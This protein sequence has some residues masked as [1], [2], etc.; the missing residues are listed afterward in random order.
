VAALG[1]AVAVAAHGLAAIQTGIA[2]FGA[3]LPKIPDVVEIE[4]NKLN[5][6][7]VKLALELKSIVAPA[8]VNQLTSL[9]DDIDNVIKAFN[10]QVDR[11]PKALEDEFTK[12]RSDIVKAAEKRCNSATEYNQA[13]WV[14][15][16]WQQK[17]S[18]HSEVI[19]II[20]MDKNACLKNLPPIKIKL[21]TRVDE[22]LRR[23][24]IYRLSDKYNKNTV[25]FF[26]RVPEELKKCLADGSTVIVA[27]IRVRNLRKN[28]GIG[29]VRQAL[30]MPTGGVWNMWGT[31]S[32][33]DNEEIH[34][35]FST[36]STVSSVAP[37][38]TFAH[39]A[40]LFN[41]LFILPSA[42]AWKEVHATL[43]VTVKVS[44]TTG[45]D[46]HPAVFVGGQTKL[47]DKYLQYRRFQKKE[48]NNV[49]QQ[50]TTDAQAAAQALLDQ[51]V[52]SMI[53][54][55]QLLLNRIAQ[56]LDIFGN[57]LPQ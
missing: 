56:G 18:L 33:Y 31:T 22:L 1:D 36:N 28:P 46:Q 11:T 29:E 32:V 38:D 45:Q 49:A 3:T 44:G 48:A 51:W 39:G 42:E 41:A 17:Q 24:R 23:Y 10:A 27:E 37:I 25:S 35:T 9:F 6:Q 14:N 16:E 54:Q 15:D 26:E 7:Q 57:Q 53:A 2:T 12:I 20:E 34:V 40:A 4:L 19:T 30:G 55:C 8:H 5:M 21:W 13:V 52:N 47:W 43:N 50:K